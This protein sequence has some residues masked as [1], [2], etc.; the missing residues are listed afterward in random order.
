M[1]TPY[2]KPL[3]SVYNAEVSRPYW[4]AAKRHELAL[5]R[6]KPCA[7][8]VWFPREI[9]PFCLSQDLEWV[10]TAGKGRLYSYT[11]VY[12]PASPSFNNDVPYVNCVVLLNEGVRINT[13]L[14]DHSPIGPNVPPVPDDIKIDMPVE[15]VFDD[16]TPDWTLPKFRPVREG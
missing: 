4:E 2:N 3:P 5:Q 8:W 12:Q 9:C 10:P 11:I 16:V 13:M 1:T 6:C 7:R 15:V 14:V